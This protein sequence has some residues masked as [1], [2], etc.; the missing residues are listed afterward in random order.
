[1]IIGGMAGGGADFFA[2]TAGG[3][4][5]LSV[6]PPAPARGATGVARGFGAGFPEPFFSAKI[7]LGKI[8]ISNKG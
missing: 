4:N 2:I 6:G 1:M 5:V 8:L 7:A 3:K